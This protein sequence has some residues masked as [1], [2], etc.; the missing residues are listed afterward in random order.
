MRATGGQRQPNA[1]RHRTCATGHPIPGVDRSSR[2]HEDRPFR[3]DCIHLL[4]AARG[5]VRQGE[6][7]ENHA[8][9]GASSRT[10]GPARRPAGD[11]RLLP[12][13]APRGGRRATGPD[14]GVARRPR[15]GAG[16]RPRDGAVGGARPARPDHVVVAL[17]ALR[18]ERDLREALRH[19]R[20]GRPRPPARR[21]AARRCP[22]AGAGSTIPRARPASSSP[23]ARRST[24]PPYAPPCERHLTKDDSAR[25]AE[26]GPITDITAPDDSHRGARL[27]D[28]VRA[29]HRLA[30]RP[31][32]DDHVADGAGR[33]RRRLRQRSRCASARSGSSTGSRRPRSPSRRTRT[34]TTPTRCSLDSITYRI[35]TDANIRA[36]NLRSGDVQVDRHRLPAGRGGAGSASRASACC[37]PARS[38]TRPSPSTSATPTAW[39]SRRVRSTR[40]WPRTRGSGRPSS[41]RSTARR[42]STRCS[43]TGS[44]RPARRSR[45]PPSSRPPPA[46]PA[47]RT[48]PTKSLAAAGARPGVDPPLPH[49][50]EGLEHPGH[51]AARAGDPGAASPTAASTSRS[52]RWSTPRCSTPQTRGDFEVAAARLVRPDRPARQHVR[53]PGHRASPATTPATATRDVDRLLT[54]AAQQVDTRAARAHVR[55]GRSSR[56]TSDD[57]LIYLY[58][59]RNLTAYSDDVAG[60]ST[61]TPT[62]WSGSATPPSSPTR[63]GR[64]TDGRSIC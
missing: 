53:L 62:A 16:R 52:S 31:G 14:D 59:Q 8:V 4:G 60:V 17:H 50:A 21:R 29:D 43:T 28:A 56:C 57:P 45:R 33:A 40:R 7:R 54:K 9:P 32:R 36:A 47:R 27:R 63:A 41:S 30:R 24:R 1:T 23:T 13:A 38:A 46:T 39:A 2:P 61:S 20:R 22:T 44:S 48:T 5:L 26:M 35:I 19:R 11:E 34:T 37:R 49:R 25:A 58:R 3:V 55:P 6:D 51:A 10:G 42:W 12:G 18:D 64:R 15:A